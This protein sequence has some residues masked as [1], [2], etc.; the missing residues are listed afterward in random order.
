[1]ARRQDT[2]ASAKANV[3]SAD[4]P[5]TSKRQEAACRNTMPPPRPAYLTNC[6][7]R[8]TCPTVTASPFPSFPQGRKRRATPPPP[9]P[10]RACCPAC[11]RLA[12]VWFAPLPRLSYPET[13]SARELVGGDRP[14]CPRAA[15]SR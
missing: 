2:E 11:W 4:E 14:R 13:E 10:A 8:R 15:V 5:D 6:G 1:M 7:Q 12:T 9:T 3:P